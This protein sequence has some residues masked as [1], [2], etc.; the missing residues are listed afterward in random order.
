MTVTPKLHT[1][2]TAAM[3]CLLSLCPTLALLHQR[4]HPPQWML[5]WR[6]RINAT[7]RLTTPRAQQQQRYVLIILVESR[8]VTTTRS[9][10]PHCHLLRRNNRII[11]S[12]EDRPLFPKLPLFLRVL[13]CLLFHRQEIR[14]FSPTKHRKYLPEARVVH[15]HCC[16]SYNNSSSKNN[17]KNK[18]KNTDERLF[19]VLF[20][21]VSSM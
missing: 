17:R 3:I 20:L 5:W 13:L 15:K 16:S 1:L 8:L 11:R 9:L 18:K 21:E 12:T 4:H 14:R 6:S 10:R 19:V 2:V 7:T